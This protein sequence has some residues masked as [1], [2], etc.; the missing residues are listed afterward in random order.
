MCTE[1]CEQLSSKNM[2]EILSVS[3][4][5][6]RML[7]SVLPRGFGEMTPMGAT[8]RIHRIIVILLKS[9]NKF[10]QYVLP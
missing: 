10:C 9:V 8:D 3:T 6:P 2:S 7:N 5:V 1:D 4:L